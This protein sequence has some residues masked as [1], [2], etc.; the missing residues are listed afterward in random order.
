MIM[1]FFFF[2]SLHKY[3]YRLGGTRS[4][5]RIYLFICNKIDCPEMYLRFKVYTNYWE[6]N[7]RVS[8]ISKFTRIRFENNSQSENVSAELTQERKIIQKNMFN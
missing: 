8:L 1:F 5:S 2:F 4:F 6:F 7:L 3:V